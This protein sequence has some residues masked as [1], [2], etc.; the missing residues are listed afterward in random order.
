MRKVINVFGGDV[1]ATTVS[2]PID[3]L[4]ARGVT[5]VCK[6]AEHASGSS[7]FTAEGG[8]CTNF[9]SYKKWIDSASKRTI[10]N[11]FSC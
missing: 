9:A 2:N 8:V 1:T 3:I 6:R 11:K 10:L 4:G 7:T 5:L